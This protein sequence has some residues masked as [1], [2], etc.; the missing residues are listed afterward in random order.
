MSVVEDVRTLKRIVIEGNGEESLVSK[1]AV[2]EQKVG[3]MRWGIR[4]LIGMA[5]GILVPVVKAW[6]Q[7]KL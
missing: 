1:V 2:L 3:E 5:L 7:G 4:L 6:I